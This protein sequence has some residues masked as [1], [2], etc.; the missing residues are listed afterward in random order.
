VSDGIN[1]V[2]LT[3]H[4]LKTEGG[5]DMKLRPIKSADLRL[6]WPV[7]ALVSSWLWCASAVAVTLSDIEFATQSGD[8]FEIVLGFDSA[9]PEPA[10]YAIESPA[11]ISIDLLG[12]ESALDKKYFRVGEGGA[13]TVAV[14]EGDD[15]TRIIV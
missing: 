11:R 8:Q 5:P 6:R 2:R 1:E 14:L 9:P 12:V 13:K 15:R 4:S 3:E 10:S 7:A